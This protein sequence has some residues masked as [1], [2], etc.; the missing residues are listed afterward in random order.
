SAIAQFSA[1]PT[2]AGGSITTNATA[3]EYEAAWRLLS[4]TFTTRRTYRIRV[5]QGPTE[6][7]AVSVDVVRGRWALT[8]SDGTLAPLVSASSLPIQ[9]HVARAVDIPPPA[10]APDE[11]A[12]NVGMSWDD[13]H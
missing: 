7:G 10:G 11:V 8:Q 4:E 5:L 2:G 9:F 3:G 6:L 1:T 12:G 13:P